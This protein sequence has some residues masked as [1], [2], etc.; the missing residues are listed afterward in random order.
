VTAKADARTEA[1]R[2]LSHTKFFKVV[3]Q[4]SIPKQTRKLILFIS[5]HQG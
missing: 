4:K 2:T 3:S 5:T 1:A